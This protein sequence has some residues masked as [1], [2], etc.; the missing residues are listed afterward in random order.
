MHQEN[1]NTIR[2]T[3][4]SPFFI[5]KPQQLIK[6]DHSVR[7]QT[8]QCINDVDNEEDKVYGNNENFEQIFC[9]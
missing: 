2:N 9:N 6:G 8:N 5:E 1:T 4:C 3:K 7:Y